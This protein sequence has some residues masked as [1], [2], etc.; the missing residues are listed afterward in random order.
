[1]Q[2]QKFNW[3]RLNTEPV[4]RFR[5]GFVFPAGTKPASE[6][7]LI[8]HPAS[9]GHKVRK[10]YLPPGVVPF[11]DL[12]EVGMKWWK[13]IFPLPAGAKEAPYGEV[14][15]G[16]RPGHSIRLG[17]FGEEHTFGFTPEQRYIGLRLSKGSGGFVPLF[18]EV[19]RNRAYSFFRLEVEWDEEVRVSVVSGPFSKQDV[20]PCFGYC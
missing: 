2:D 17:R 19:Q 1:M 10:W 18:M 13:A 7:G 15:L 9:L 20:P 16:S 6:E 11:P 8:A 14:L 5:I 12:S 4:L 3:L